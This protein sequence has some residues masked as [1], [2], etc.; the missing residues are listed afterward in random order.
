MPNEKC[1][2]FLGWVRENV[3]REVPIIGH[4]LSDRT[5]SAFQ[6]DMKHFFGML[7]G[8]AAMMTIPMPMTMSTKTPMAMQAS[9][10]VPEHKDNTAEL[11]QKFTLMTLYMY[12][13]MFIGGVLFNIGKK[14]L[15][16]CKATPSSTLQESDINDL[17]SG[18]LNNSRSCPA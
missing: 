14:A 11:L 8:M 6:H 10:A 16:A 9:T 3:V 5:W 13:G 12:V 7:L 17:D 2:L 18:L 1:T 4:T 15:S